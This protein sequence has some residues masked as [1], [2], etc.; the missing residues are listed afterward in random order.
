MKSDNLFL[1]FIENMIKY[2]HENRVFKLFIFLGGN[3]DEKNPVKANRVFQLS[4]HAYLLASLAAL[5]ASATALS[6]AAFA[7]CAPDS[8]ALAAEAAPCFAA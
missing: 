7:P 6:A 1:N 5:A 8:T 3:S 2:V 4:N